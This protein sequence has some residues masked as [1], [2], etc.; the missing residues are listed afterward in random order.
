MTRQ[1]TSSNHS[2]IEPYSSVPPFA[3]MAGFTCIISLLIVL[4]VSQNQYDLL[5]AICQALIIGILAFVNPTAGIFAVLVFSTTTGFWS[6]LALHLANGQPSAFDFIRFSVELV[7]LLFALQV[8]HQDHFFRSSSIKGI[9]M[10]VLLYLAISSFAALNILF[11]GPITTIWGWRWVCLP[12]LMYYLG[13]R[14]GLQEK[15]VQAFYRLSIWLLLVLSAFAVYQIVIGLLPFELTWF[16]QLPSIDQMG[17]AGSETSLFIGGELRVPSVTVGYYYASF[18]IAFLFLLVLFLPG[19]SLFG[20]YSMLRMFALIA[21]ATYF[22][23]SLERAAIGAV[24]IGLFVAICLNVW[25]RFGSFALIVLMLSALLTLLFLQTAVNTL[26]ASVEIR[27]VLELVNPLNAAT[28]RWRVVNAWSPALE[29]AIRNPIGYGLGATQGI[30]QNV[31]GGTFLRPHN[32]YLQI[33]LEQGLVGLFLFLVVM[34][35]YSQRFTKFVK[36]GGVFPFASSALA[37]IW[38][39]LV[40]GFFNIPLEFPVGLFFWFSIGLFVALS[41]QKVRLNA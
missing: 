29:Q 41:S 14:V 38:S 28:V 4:L 16:N 30:R 11:V 34:V 13:R 20:W 35:R 7:V 19:G 12:L 3:W 37:P 36:K 25:R 9:D 24:I 8:I 21:S 18:L 39:L 5:F 1:M 32:I 15:G 22:S 10:A 26:G 27:R 31:E 2:R 40:L 23:L 6:R 17:N 33:L